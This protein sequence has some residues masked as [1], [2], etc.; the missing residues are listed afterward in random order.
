MH[1]I[2][3]NTD[4]WPGAILNPAAAAVGEFPDLFA[5]LLGFALRRLFPVAFSAKEKN[6]GQSTKTCAGFDISLSVKS[7]VSP[8]VLGRLENLVE[9]LPKQLGLGQHVGPSTSEGP[10]FSPDGRN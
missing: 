8:F 7:H 5:F 1:S 2:S 10:F 3:V 9:I 6:R 4:S